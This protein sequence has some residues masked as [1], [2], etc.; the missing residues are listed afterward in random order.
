MATSSL[1]GTTVH[2]AAQRTAEM[3]DVLL[4]PLSDAVAAE[5]LIA[6]LRAH[7][8]PESVQLSAADVPGLRHDPLVSAAAVPGMSRPMVVARG[9]PGGD[10]VQLDD[11]VRRTVAYFRNARPV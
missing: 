7:G 3:T 6:V 11:G 2:D 1:L 10:A 5:R 9:L 8:E 4:A